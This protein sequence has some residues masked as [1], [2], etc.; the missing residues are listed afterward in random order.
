LIVMMAGLPGT[1]KST[2]ARALAARI[3]GVV[4]DKDLIRASVFPKH[5]IEYSTAQD[6]FVVELMLSTSAY[7]LWGDP[8]AIVILDGR[9]FS[10]KYQVDMVVAFA[11]QVGTPLRIVE[12][13]CSEK[14]ALRRLQE[15]SAKGRHVAGNRN[16][17]LYREV[18]ARFQ[19]IRRRK[20]VVR[21]ALRLDTCVKKV[22]EYLDHDA[23]LPAPSTS[24]RA[25]SVA[26]RQGRGIRCKS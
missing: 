2:L 22:V 19:E 10:R 18:K 16:A 14:V 9:T 5:L 24:L 15:D 4:L 8:A 1:G 3:S 25:G 21:T 23:E 12:C 20:L 13:V 17:E 26:G 7:L 11:K 6:D